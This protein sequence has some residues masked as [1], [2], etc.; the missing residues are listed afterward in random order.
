MVAIGFFFLRLS[1]RI[2]TSPGTALMLSIVARSA[3]CPSSWR[4]VWFVAADFRTS[5][6]NRPA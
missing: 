4:P 3:S 1:P 2:F 6:K 5:D